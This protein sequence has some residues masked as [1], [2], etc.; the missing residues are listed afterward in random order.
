MSTT[1]VSRPKAPKALPYQSRLDARKAMLESSARE[2]RMRLQNNLTH[3]TK[4]FPAIAAEEVVSKVSAKNP[5]AGKLLRTLGVGEKFVDS[6]MVTSSI[7][8]KRYL[9]AGSSAAAGTNRLGALAG[10]LEEWALPFIT[11][12]GSHK[13]L[14][15]ALGASGKL[16]R[17]GISGGLKL[18][19]GKKR[20]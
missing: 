3:L 13:L 17:S 1:P 12:F 15:V 18:L 11:T 9:G 10:L 6:R 14:S 8:G 7:D 2:R 5:R 16:L 19:F 4:N 20:K